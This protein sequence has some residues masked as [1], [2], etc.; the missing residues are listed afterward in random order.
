MAL[1][2]ADRVKE[3]TTTTGTG[4]VT[5]LGAS[6]GFQSFAAVGDANTTYYTIAAQ[7][8]TE[9]EVGIGTYATSGT[10]L[11]R[12]VVLSSSNSGSAVDF[13]A[14]TKDVF[15]TYPSERAVIG[16]EGYVENSATVAVSSTITAGN[17]AMSAGPVTINSGITVTV[18][19][20]SRWVVV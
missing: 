3:T 16:G 5:L 9:W 13:S 12:T 2:L 14:G 10:T 8:G 1:V 17:N 18:P 20:G 7:T 11:A 6:T 4:T 15:V 19:S